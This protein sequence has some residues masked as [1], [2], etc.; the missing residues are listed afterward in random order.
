MFDRVALSGVVFGFFLVGSQQAADYHFVRSI[1]VGE[2]YYPGGVATDSSGNIWVADAFNHRIQEFNTSG[3]NLNSFGGW[4]TGNGDFGYPFFLA[5]DPWQNVW[6]SD[7]YLNRIQEF[8]SSG[9]YLTQFGANGSG[10]G[11]FICS[12]APTAAATGNLVILTA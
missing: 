9:T 11:E 2:L 4:G 8:N 1:G 10:T 12:S 3:A 6:V 5:V 7:H